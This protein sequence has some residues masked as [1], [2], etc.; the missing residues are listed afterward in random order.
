MKFVQIDDV[1]A[2]GFFLQLPVDVLALGTY[3]Y[4]RMVYDAAGCRRDASWVD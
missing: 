4:I 2:V 1:L 3:I